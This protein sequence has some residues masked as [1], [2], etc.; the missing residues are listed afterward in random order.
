MLP[1]LPICLSQ[2][3]LEASRVFSSVGEFSEL[4][5]ACYGPPPVPVF[6][7]SMDVMFPLERCFIS[8]LDDRRIPECSYL[9]KSIV[10]RRCESEII[11]TV[12]KL[13]LYY[14][15]KTS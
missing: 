14:Y 9:W 15:K 6:P 11:D 2:L 7:G 3:F 8:V 1:S 13:G 5:P 12:P 10:L 4:S